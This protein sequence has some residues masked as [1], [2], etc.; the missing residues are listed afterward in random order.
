LTY[1]LL[2]GLV[3][4]P[5]LLSR[6]PKLGPAPGGIVVSPTAPKLDM[7][8]E[9]TD[10]SD[11]AVTKP[12]VATLTGQRP[13]PSNEVNARAVVQIE[14]HVQLASPEALDRIA[15]ELE[16]H[17]HIAVLP[18][19]KTAD[20]YEAMSTFF[21]LF[22]A[23]TMAPTA[24]PSGLVARRDGANN[25]PR[26]YRGANIVAERRY[27]D[28]LKQLVHGWTRH[29]AG[30]QPL[31]L[32]PTLLFFAAAAGAAT[33]FVFAPGWAT[34]GVYAAAVFAVSVSIKQVAKFTRLFTLIYPV[35]LLFFVGVVIRSVFVRP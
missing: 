15:A 11:E 9:I 20:R 22:D 16:H 30:S 8:V 13:Q 24:P 35:T 26:V 29:R 32:I 12:L 27:P 18:W 33:R 10:V 17:P 23:M 6:L 34:F 14:P 3:L 25:P 31:L 28:G 7:R 4:G 1:L 2:A 19:H 5:L 21:V